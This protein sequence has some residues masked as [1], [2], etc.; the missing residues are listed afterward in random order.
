MLLLIL[1]VIAF[2][3]TS[4]GFQQ[5]TE[6]LGCRM[7][8][9]ETGLWMSYAAVVYFNM[10]VLIP[11]FAL[12]QKYLSYL[13]AL[14]F[15]MMFLLFAKLLME[16]AAFSAIDIPYTFNYINFLDNISYFA[17]NTIC[18]TGIS[19]TGLLKRRSEDQMRIDRLENERLQSEVGRVKE[20]INPQFLSDILRQ[21]SVSAK[22]DPQKASE[23]L[24]KLSEL[25]R[26]ELYDCNRS[27]VL[28][29][30]DIRFIS[31]YLELE[32]LYVDNFEYSLSTNEKA[33]PLFIPPL[34]L[35]PFIQNVLGQMRRQG[36]NHRLQI[37]LNANRNAIFFICSANGV[38][39]SA[40]DFSIVERRLKMLCEENYTLSITKDTVELRL[41]LQKHGE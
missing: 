6:K 25:L 39:L 20:Q 32:R 17:L 21:T 30:S 14:G 10:Y 38:D 8:L 18:I 19:I 34:L 11:R 36:N 29:S 7:Y 12:S 3:Q 2:N 23:M 41:I 26:Y 24:F 37:S 15:L 16:R 9:L 4:W 40:S 5:Y 27:E 35:M 13:A 33:N 1:A 31:V 28:V 22:T